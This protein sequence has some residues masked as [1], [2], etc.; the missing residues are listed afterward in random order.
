MSGPVSLGSVCLHSAT[1]TA[2][3]SNTHMQRQNTTDRER[4]KG[5]EQQSRVHLQAGGA[6]APY[7]MFPWRRV[8]H[9]GGREMPAMSEILQHKLQR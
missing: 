8:V 9:V 2:A 4:D 6:L 7:G 5:K 1:L 3:E